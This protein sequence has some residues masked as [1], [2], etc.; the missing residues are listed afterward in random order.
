MPRRIERE[1]NDTKMR[2]KTVVQKI[3][4]FM[5]IIESIQD[6][7]TAKQTKL[8]LITVNEVNEPF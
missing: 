5:T 4:I 1:R 7:T 2:P 6:A 3:V 8:N